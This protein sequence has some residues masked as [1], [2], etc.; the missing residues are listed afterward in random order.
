MASFML[1]FVQRLLCSTASK[2]GPTG[3]GKRMLADIVQYVV[4]QRPTT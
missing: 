3:N 2:F 4:L 1:R